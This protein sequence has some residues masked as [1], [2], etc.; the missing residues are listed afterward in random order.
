M[1]WLAARKEYDRARILKSARSAA[2]RGRH[3]KAIALYERVHEVEPENV[4]VLRR[5]AAQ[6]A[7]AGQHEEAWRDC[8]LVAERLTKQGFVDQAIGVLRDFAHHLPREI[9]VW[10]S[11]ARL[12]F[13]RDRK[14]DA[15]AALLEGRAVF[16]GRKDR[17]QALMLLRTARKID[18]T[19]FAAN[20]ALAGLLASAGNKPHAIRILQELEGHT[21]G[22][23][24]R[25]LRG[26]L[27][28]LSP[29][30]RTAWRW[31]RSCFGGR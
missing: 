5:L 26:R 29:G 21:Q 17:E 30:P 15:I 22:R 16:K 7:R 27:F 20:F 19:H 12:Q 11:L 3:Q 24:R 28:R 4:D 13:D 25:R 9:G 10:T 1:A 18:V 6:R 14:P 2:R 31:V 8:Q 23:E